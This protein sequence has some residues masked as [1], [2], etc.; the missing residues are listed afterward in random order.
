MLVH[1]PPQY[2]PGPLV[3]KNV[4]HNEVGLVGEKQAWLQVS[5]IMGLNHMFRWHPKCHAFRGRSTR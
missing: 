4:A 3:G 1:T 2:I 5:E